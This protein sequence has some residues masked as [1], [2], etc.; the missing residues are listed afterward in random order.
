MEQK[1]V[2]AATF[3]TCAVL[4][5]LCALSLWVWF[6]W[7]IEPA[8]GQIAV[9][10][11]KT[12]RNLPPDAILAP[13]AEYKGIQEDVLPEG[14]Y[15]RNPWTWEWRYAKMVDVPA[16]KFGVLV[17]RFGKDLPEGE[18]IA[19]D[20]TR[21]ILRDVLGTGKHRINPYAYEVKL[22][23]DITVKPGHVGVVTELTGDDILAPGGAKDP[24]TG[25][26]FL[27]KD[28]AK[29][30]S[31][32]ILKEGTHR[33]NPFV[34]SV[35]IVNI[36]SQRFELS[37][38][39]A[40]SFLTLDGFTVNAEGTLEFNLDVD[41]VALLSHEVGDMDD[42][43]QKIVLPAARGFSRIE[44]SKKNA[45]EFIVGESRQ[46]FQDSLEKYLKDVCKP[47]GVS[48]NSVLI[49]DIFAPQEVASIIRQ[50]ELAVQEGRKIE[51]QIVQAKSQAELERQ[52]ALAAQNSARV[53]AE[54]KS[55]QA[56]IAAE[57][58]SVEKVVA[59]ETQLEV[60]TREL[61]AAQANATARLTEAEASRKVVEV[62]SKA[63]ADVLRQ[64]VAAY[65]S[66]GD[67]VRAKLYEKTAPRLRDV[68]TGDS[69]GEVFGLPIRAAKKEGGAK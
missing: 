24:A 9:L 60:A 40:I 7:R 55:I 45:T 44:G 42:I 18:I 3:G 41:K 14:R 33:L 46:A 35:S 1:T 47:W 16:G 27:V 65:G 28:G 6:G 32:R 48:L 11:K 10:L 36:Q 56:K 29:G 53:A 13:G 52:K 67:Y 15:F 37:G 43:L 57:Q 69:P 39:D 4:V 20:G 49:R 58:A 59:A 51:Q 54:T 5:A 17:R 62:E 50:R 26:G 31:P 68:V 23:D 64:T 66:E 38:A 2:G 19:R 63:A 22:Y 8:N 61:K 21:G 34:Y 12:G 25:S 30:V